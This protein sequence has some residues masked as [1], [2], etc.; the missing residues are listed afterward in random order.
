MCRVAVTEELGR[1]AKLPDWVPLMGHFP[2]TDKAVSVEWD[3]QDAWL[4]GQLK[5]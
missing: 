2:L 3:E 5:A 4:A 1:A